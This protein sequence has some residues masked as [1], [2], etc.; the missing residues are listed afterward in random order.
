MRVFFLL[1]LTAVAYSILLETKTISVDDEDLSE[2]VDVLTSPAIEEVDGDDYFAEFANLIPDELNVEEIVSEDA[3]LESDDN[4]AYYGEAN[5]YYYY[6]TPDDGTPD[7][8]TNVEIIIQSSAPRL[9]GSSIR[10]A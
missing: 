6:I 5:D 9:R 8:S 4:Y 10:N 3:S 1:L 2:S 7:H